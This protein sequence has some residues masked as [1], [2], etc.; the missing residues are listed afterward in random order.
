[1]KKTA[2]NEVLNQTISSGVTTM[3]TY[4]K[5]DK[6]RAGRKKIAAEARTDKNVYFLLNAEQ[7]E[8]LKKIAEEECLSYQAFVKKEILKIIKAY[9]LKESSLRSFNRKT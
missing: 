1:M 3:N 4:E 7:F 9:T 5:A 6:S 8:T 2:I